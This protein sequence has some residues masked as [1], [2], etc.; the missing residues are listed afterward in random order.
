MTRVAFNPADTP[1]TLRRG[2]I[3][4]GGEWAAV[5]PDEKEVREAVEAGRLVLLETDAP[6][7]GAD[8][9]PS[10][11]AAFDEARPLASARKTSSA[12]ADGN[13]EDAGKSGGK[14]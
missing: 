4:G 6:D 10:A 11:R 13:T 3:V 12:S 8:A 14:G 5:D 1:L 9:H 7:P 2:R